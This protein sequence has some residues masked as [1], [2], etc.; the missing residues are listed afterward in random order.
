MYLLWNLYTLYLHS[1]RVRVTVGDSGLCSCPR[2]TSFK[3][4]LTPLCWN[5]LKWLPCF[6]LLK[7]AQFTYTSL[8]VLAGQGARQLIDW[9]YTLLHTH[10]QPIMNTAL[11]VYL[12][13]GFYDLHQYR[14]LDF[15]YFWGLGCFACLTHKMAMVLSKK[16]WHIYMKSQVYSG[17]M[18]KKAKTTRKD[19]Q[20]SKERK[21]DRTDRNRE[22]FFF[23]PV[24]H[25]CL[26]NSSSS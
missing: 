24:H 5:I 6:K 1:C 17:H 4:L 11:S 12:P 2:V 25:W 8:S 18:Y 15:V 20:E 21:A 13:T 9:H 26:F 10:T 14:L 22:Y 7:K 19:R 16:T 3:H 23:L